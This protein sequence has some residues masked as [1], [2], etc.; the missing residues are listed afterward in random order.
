[1]KITVSIEITGGTPDQRALLGAAFDTAKRRAVDAGMD[2]FEAS[3]YAA[4]CFARAAALA[5]AG[6]ITDVD[7]TLHLPLPTEEPTQ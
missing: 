5:H 2:T 1:M 6:D 3:M 4:G 7:V